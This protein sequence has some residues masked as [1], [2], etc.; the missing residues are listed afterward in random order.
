MNLTRA[1]SSMPK[2]SAADAIGNSSISSVRT[3]SSGE[4]L[5]RPKR[6]CTASTI[7]IERPCRSANARIVVPGT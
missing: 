2:P 6:T 7:S 4:G 3:G 5:G 1:A